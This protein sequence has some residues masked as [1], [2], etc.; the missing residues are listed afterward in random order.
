MFLSTGCSV[1]TL[2]I[3]VRGT[4]TRA[5]AIRSRK[6]VLMRCRRQFNVKI[7]QTVDET[8]SRVRCDSTLGRGKKT[9]DAGVY[10][11]NRGRVNISSS[12]NCRPLSLVF[13]CRAIVTNKTF[14]T[15]KRVK[16]TYASS[17]SSPRAQYI[18]GRRATRISITVRA[19]W[20]DIYFSARAMK[21]FRRL[22]NI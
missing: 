9:R 20:C 10:Q 21:T 5:D 11:N 14:R 15:F 19:Y 2:R 1:T 17:R 12:V 4:D 8:S 7:F 22:L 16:Y 6:C 3:L 18:S 13:D